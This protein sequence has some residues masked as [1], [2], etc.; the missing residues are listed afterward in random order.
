MLLARRTLGPL[1]NSFRKSSHGH[2]HTSV[3]APV[4]YTGQSPN[5]FIEDG[6]SGARLPID[7]RNKWLFAAKAIAFLGIGYWAPFFI[8]EYQLRKNNA[9]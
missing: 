8:V 1:L 4:K 6:W 5:G 3:P 2:G 9:H 7:V